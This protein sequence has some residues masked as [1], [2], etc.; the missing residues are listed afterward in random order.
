MPLRFAVCVQT[1]ARLLEN[2][3]GLNEALKEEADKS[4]K[5][6]GNMKERRASAALT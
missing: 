1:V 5:S 2:E 6:V 4:K 3:A